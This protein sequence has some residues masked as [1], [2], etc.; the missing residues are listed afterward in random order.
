MNELLAVA[1]D[2]WWLVLPLSALAFE[3]WS[4][5]AEKR[6]R[7][8]VELYRLEHPNAA[9]VDPEDLA[10]YRSAVTA[11]DVA[12]QVAETEARRVK[13]SGFTVDE[14]TRLETARKLVTVAVDDAA[15]AAER[16][17]AYRRARRELDGLIVLPDATIDSLEQ[18]VAGA[19]GSRR[20]SSPP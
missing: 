16:Q 14:R 5:A 10:A 19:I 15:T 12:F 11:Y 7:R 6:H 17:A 8:R 1:G 20:G 18:S 4:E 3:G 13:A 2:Y 9:H